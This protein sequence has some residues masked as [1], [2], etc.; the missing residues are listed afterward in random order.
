MSTNNT[1]INDR[2]CHNCGLLEHDC[3]AITKENAFGYCIN[4]TPTETDWYK[5]AET[6]HKEHGQSHLIDGGDENTPI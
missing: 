6:L 5:F 2:Y 4:W 1:M 3:H